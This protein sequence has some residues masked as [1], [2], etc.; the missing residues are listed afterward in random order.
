[1]LKMQTLFKHDP[2]AMKAQFDAVDKNKDGKL[3]KRELALF[4]KEMDQRHDE[5]QI[6]MIMD[7]CDATRDGYLTFDQFMIVQDNIINNFR[8]GLDG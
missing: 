7:K 3:N 8:R 5:K 6:N 1:M 2:D 4:L